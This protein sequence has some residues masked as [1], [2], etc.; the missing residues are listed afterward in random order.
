MFMNGK[1]PGGIPMISFTWVDVRDVAQ[2]HLNCLERD[3][4]QG[5]RFIV[6]HQ[7]LWMR[8]VA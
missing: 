2:A 3:E 4:A 8:E 6:A 7:N 5:K 1:L